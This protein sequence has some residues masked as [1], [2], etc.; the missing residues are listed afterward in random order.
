MNSIVEC[1][2]ENLLKKE[3]CA[4]P[5]LPETILLVT[6]GNVLSTGKLKID[7]D[8]QYIHIHL[9]YL[10]TTEIVG[11]KREHLTDMNI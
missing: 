6:E 3:A 9:T 8:L 11:T 1:I 10:R 4:R 2:W 7:L 5:G